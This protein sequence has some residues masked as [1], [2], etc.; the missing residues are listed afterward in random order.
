MLGLPGP[1]GSFVA[2]AAALALGGV[3]AIATAGRAVLRSRAFAI[4]ASGAAVGT[5]ALLLSPTGRRL[6][7]TGPPIGDRI[8]L[9]QG[10]LRAFLARPILGWGPDGLA[11]GFGSV[12]PAGMEDIYAPGD[13]AADQAHNWVLQAFATTGIVG[14]A[15]LLVMLG[16]FAV[17]LVR[18]R[19]GPLAAVV[20]PLILASLAYWANGLSSPESVSIGWI[21]WVVFAAIAWLVVRAPSESPRLGGLRSWAPATALLGSV[22]I[23]ATG[24]NAYRANVEI[25]RSVV[26]YPRDANETIAGAN[27]AIALD[28]GRGDYWNYR[29]LGFQLRGQFALAAADFAVAAERQ[30][31]QSSYWINLSRSRLFQL[32]QGDFSGGGAAAAIAAAERAVAAD[33]Q[34]SAPHRNYAEVA[35]ALGDPARA[36]AA[37]G[38]ALGLYAG[39]PFIDVVLGQAGVQL[40]DHERARRALELALARK[41]GSPVLWAALA[42]VQLAGGNVDAARSAALRTLEL[43]PSSSDARRV[44][45]ATGP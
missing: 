35:L 41:S 11:T 37:A 36:L 25:V 40:P 30:R 34:L 27:A 17:V 3:L 2:L 43:D 9:W 5:I 44:L 12:R 26:T 23:A 4:C 10:T 7:L 14:G 39:D 16:A 33:P 19:R 38:T 1:R 15:A 24:W 8:L 21:P 42:Q 6:V 22:A 45:G 32:Q 28:P 18:R 29:G 13:L 31:Y 20:W